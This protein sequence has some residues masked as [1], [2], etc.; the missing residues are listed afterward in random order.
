MR[1]LRMGSQPW[2]PFPVNTGKLRRTT[3]RREPKAKTNRPHAQMFTE[4]FFTVAERR[5]QSR[6]PP[7]GEWRR[8]IW[9]FLYGG[10]LFSCR[11]ECVPDTCYNVDGP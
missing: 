5:K 3:V 4:L 1:H 8:E 9:C 11:K 10:I 7:A 6:C 2:A